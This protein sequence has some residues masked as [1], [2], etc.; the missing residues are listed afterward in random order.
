[1]VYCVCMAS[2]TV[3]DLPVSERPRERLQKYGAESVSIQELL[4][5][6]LGRGIAGES[7]L[8]T[9]QKIITHFGD[10]HAVAQASLEDLQ[11]IHGLGFAKACQLKACFEIARR[12][13]IP[14]QAD[15]KN[16]QLQSPPSLFQLIREHIHE[17]S[18]EHFLVISLD[19]RNCFIAIDTVSIGTLNASLVHPRE[20]FDKAIRR[21]AA[22]VIVAHNH[23]SNNPDPSFEDIEI[24]K[25]LVNAGTVL[26]IKVIDHIIVTQKDYISLR[27][28]N[29]M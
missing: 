18:K 11:S 13:G 10:I 9:A 2:F 16:T 22:H 6:I 1:M 17:Y 7:V 19:T 24:T 21:H 12:I 28:K 25:R 15:I 27:E 23:P 8:L 20:V 14:K 29:I 4:A 5:I 3:H 26:G